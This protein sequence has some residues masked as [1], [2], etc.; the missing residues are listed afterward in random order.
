MTKGE[1]E[2]VAENEYGQEGGE[3]CGEE[4]AA[5]SSRWRRLVVSIANGG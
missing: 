1:L 2:S 5:M 3:G 4:G